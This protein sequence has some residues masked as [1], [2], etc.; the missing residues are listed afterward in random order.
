VEICPLHSSST[1][2]PHICE[3]SCICFILSVISFGCPR[4]VIDFLT[5]LPVMTLSIISVTH[6]SFSD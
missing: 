1:S 5:L 6:S 3:L 4:L 2:F